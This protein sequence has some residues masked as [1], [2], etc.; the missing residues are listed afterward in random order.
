MERGPQLAFPDRSLPDPSPLANRNTAFFLE[1]TTLLFRQTLAAQA[2]HG[3]TLLG[4]HMGG[5]DAQKMMALMRMMG[6]T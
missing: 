4:R 3:D 1:S 2:S 6:A 5:M